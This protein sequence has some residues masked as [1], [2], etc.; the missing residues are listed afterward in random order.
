MTKTQEWV[1]WTGPTRGTIKR[2][3]HSF[4]KRICHWSYCARCGLVLLKNDASRAAAKRDCV[5]EE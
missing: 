5:V 2:G 4:T 1:P 3:A